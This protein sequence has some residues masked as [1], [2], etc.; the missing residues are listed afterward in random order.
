[1]VYQRL[2]I[3]R[4]EVIGE[5]IKIS[6]KG[7]EIAKDALP[8]NFIM[9]KPDDRN[10]P[11]LPRPFAILDTDE[12]IFDILIKVKG[13]GTRIISERPVGDFLFI[14]GPSG[15]PFIPSERGILIG[16][17]IGIASLIFLS[18][19]M[20]GGIVFLGAKTRDG[21]FG[22]EILEKRNFDTHIFTE[23]GSLGEKGLV[24]NGL[25]KVLQRDVSVPIFGCGPLPM[26][27]WLKTFSEKEGM[28]TYLFL[29]ERMACGMGVCKGCAVRTTSGYKLVCKDGPVFLAEDVIL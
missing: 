4:K 26:L 28:K 1:M 22:K 18:K 13:R 6:L 19:F 15:K 9:V 17:G 27:K 2:K 10:D 14:L 12:E 8:G 29:E 11:L 21:I 16:G 23:D 5:Y 20:K 7:R 24:I 25:K 3:V